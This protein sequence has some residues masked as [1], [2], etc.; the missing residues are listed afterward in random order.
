MCTSKVICM[1]EVPGIT[2]Q[3]FCPT[4]DLE[5]YRSYAVGLNNQQ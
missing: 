5:S 4:S 1:D 2:F 3:T